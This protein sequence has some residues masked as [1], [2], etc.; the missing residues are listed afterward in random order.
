LAKLPECFA[1]EG[2]MIAEIMYLSSETV[3]IVLCLV[4]RGRVFT[5]LWLR[6]RGR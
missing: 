6:R 3:A 1:N 2:A 4:R 5:G